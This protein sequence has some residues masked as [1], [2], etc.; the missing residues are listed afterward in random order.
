MAFNLF[1]F[2]IQFLYFFLTNIKIGLLS[3]AG[4]LLFGVPFAFALRYPL[5]LN[6]L[7]NI[8]L[9]LCRGFPVYILMFIVFNNINSDE[10]LG[11]FKDHTIRL[12]A[13]VVA[14]SAYA[15]AAV[16][17]AM[18]DCLKNA[19]NGNTGQAYL[20]VPNIFRIFTIAM[21]SSSIG[22]AIDVSE[23]VSYTVRVYE[24]FPDRGDRFLLVLGVT[25]FFVIVQ[26]T[27]KL[28]VLS[29][30]QRIQKSMQKTG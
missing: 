20:I 5:R 7:I 6:A 18:S 23:A 3:L 12:I 1:D 27:L 28:L 10:F 25:I 13:V 22:A 11:D 9:T 4:G 2:I 16:C 30:S 29:L 15:T 24:N 21:I 8:I 17:D 19:A 14:L 26:H